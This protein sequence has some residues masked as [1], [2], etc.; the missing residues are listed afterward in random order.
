MTYPKTKKQKHRSINASTRKKTIIHLPKALPAF[1]PVPP[2]LISKMPGY[3]FYAFINGNWLSSVKVPPFRSAFGVS[4]EL[5]EKIKKELS[6]LVNKGIVLAKKGKKQKG[7]YNI[8]LETVGRFGLSA[9]RPSVQPHS[10]KLLKKMVAGIQCMRDMKDICKTF[11]EFARLRITGL[12]SIFTYYESGKTIIAHLALAPGQLGLPDTSYYFKT[13]PGKSK[14]LLA[15]GRLLDDVAKLLELD[16]L[17]DVIQIESILAKA[18]YESQTEHEIML[19]GSALPKKYSTF[20]WDAFW[21][22]ISLDSW[23]QNLIK[24]Y[25][26]SWINTI[27]KLFK[28]FTIDQWKL[29]FTTQLVLH[30][31]PLL[32]PPFDDIHSN[33]YER[34]L[35]GQKEKLPQHELTLRLLQEWMPSTMSR[36]YLRHYIDPT[37]KS[38]VIKFTN[39]IRISA[40]HRIQNTAWLEPTTR[41][42]AVN[43][44]KKMITGVAY[45]EK[46]PEF[47]QLNLQT[48]NLF[49][50]ILFLGED[51]TKS[52]LLKLNKTIDIENRWEDA[53]YA[54]NAYYYSE[55]NQIIL[56]AGSLQWPFY[57]LLAPQGWNFGGLGAVIGHEMTHAFDSDG[58]NYN[59]YGVEENWWTVKDNLEYKKRTSALV[60]LFNKS[61]VLGHSVNGILTLN[62]N[63]SDL[64][65]LAIALDALKIEITSQKLTKEA[66]KQAYQNFFIAYSVSW[67]IKEKQE[68]ILQ[69]LFLDRHAPAPLRVNL[70]VSQF[71]EWY[72]AFDIKLSDKLYIPPEERIRIF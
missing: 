17:S 60:E 55:V 35:R 15:Y 37:L 19:Q 53:I 65:G 23:K 61:K 52:D 59:E 66:E 8:S 39:L 2:N 29:L 6:I 62:E 27:E 33:F 67:R 45:P 44:V 3:D 43:K 63:I 42:K 24:I 69:G 28:V 68:K 58:K 34:R 38:T 49:K 57:H 51:S 7:S 31:L 18:M 4:E 46:M 9:L 5:E 32:P 1:P 50:N 10:V 36:L 16:N 40:I 30:A 12:F 20:D 70:I 48:D 22:G 21:D 71:D 26:P 41:R 25:S 54:V 72:D 64:G 14:T 13:A 56:P 47:P 11:G